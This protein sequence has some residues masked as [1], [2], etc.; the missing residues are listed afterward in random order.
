MSMQRNGM[1]MVALA[2]VLA[3]AGC[4]GGDAEAAAGEDTSTATRIINVQTQEMRPQPFT[5][6]L[7]L[8]GA[9]AADR[10]VTVAAEESGVVRELFVEKGQ[11]VSE[12]QPLARI[13]DRVLRAQAEQATAQAELAGETWQRQRR[14]WEVDSVG[15]EMMYIQ[16]RQQYLTAQAN[17]RALN[18][19]LSRTVVRAPIGGLVEDRMVEVG[20]MVAPGAPVARIV[21]VNPVKVV[22]GMPERFA[23]DI[24]AGSPAELFISALGNRDFAG[25]VSFVGASVDPQSRTVPVEVAVPNPGGLLRPGMVADVRI[26]REQYEG[27]MVIPQ[28]AVLRSEDGYYVFVAVERDGGMHAEM[29][30]VVVGESQQGLVQVQEGVQEGDRVIVVGQK[31]VTAG[32]RLNIVAGGGDR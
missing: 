5:D 30:P 15:S 9:A 27:A 25:R 8:T 17:A 14:L 1:T 11:A 4:G 16:A 2:G 29:R 28:D 7:N 20:A 23:T 22:A 19:R 31:Q 32:D 18:E 10:D 3:L 26:A 12:G 13:D 6:Y 21:D 24:E